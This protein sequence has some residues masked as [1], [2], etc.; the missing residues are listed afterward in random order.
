[1]YYRK[2]IKS[3]QNIFGTTD[4]ELKDTSLRVGSKEFPIRNDVIDLTASGP[5][6]HFAEDIQYTFGAEWTSHGQLRPEHETEF[7]Q[8]F[9]LVSLEGL[10]DQR[11]CDLGCGSGRWSFHLK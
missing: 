11:I 7:A 5:S 9:D 2:Q 1:M 10:R 3:L 8:Y 6:A 4:I